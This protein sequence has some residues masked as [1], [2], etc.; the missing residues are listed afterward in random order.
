MEH[1]DIRPIKNIKEIN[2]LL[3]IQK[4]VWGLKDID[5]VPVHIFKAVSGFMGPKGIILGYFIDGKLSAY[6]L[7]FPTS[8]PKEVFGGMLAVSKNYQHK[9]I[10]YKLNLEL[11]KIMLAHDVDKIS[12]T[13]DPLESVNANLYLNKLGGIITHH[14]TDYYGGLNSQLHFGLSTDRFKVEWNIKEPPIKEEIDGKI[15]KNYEYKK[16]DCSDIR[17]VEIPLNIQHIKKINIEEALEWRMKTRAL[18]D[19]YIEKQKLIGINFIR[20]IVNQKGIYV[21]KKPPA[22]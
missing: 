4:E 18:F 16:N 12:W 9:G 14:F 13:Y 17:Y 20:D 8:N 15:K 11:R 7:T 2:E 6:L 5:I 1:E 19:K 3:F 10:G 22:R 21:F